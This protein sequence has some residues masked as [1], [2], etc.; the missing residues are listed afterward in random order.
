MTSSPASAGTP[1]LR[2]AWQR[3]RVQVLALLAVVGASLAY[4]VYVASECS[5][6]FDEASTI[7]DVDA[8]LPEL[9]RGPSR[10]HPPLM[11]WL[12]RLATALLGRSELGLRAV[13]LAFGCLLLLAVYLLALE[14]GLGATRA[15]VPVASLAVTPFFI[16]HATEA[17]QYA[18][19]A[20]FTTLATVFALRL[21]ARPLRLSWLVGLA[22]CSVAAAATHFFALPYAL[23]LWGSVAVGTL[24]AWK[25]RTL[26]ARDRK[27]LV[28]VVVA[29][30][31]LLGLLCADLFGL[32]RYYAHHALG[33]GGHHL[34]LASVW[35]AFSFLARPPWD[36]AYEALVSALG[37][38]VVAVR[39]RGL[40]RIIPLG[41]AFPP[42]AAVTLLSSGHMFTPR[43]LWP[44]FVFYHFGEVSAVL[45]LIEFV[46]W[47]VARAGAL[48]R[49][50]SVVAWLVLLV[51]FQARLSEFPTGFGAGGSIN[52]RALQR[53]FG[54]DRAEDTALVVYVG[55]AGTRI[56][57]SAY[58][59]PHLLTLEHFEPLPG[60]TRYLVAEFDSSDHRLHSEFAPLLKRQLGLSRSQ[61]RA[62]PQAKLAGNRFQRA[63][64][65]RLVVLDPA[66]SREGARA[67]GPQAPSPEPAEHANEDESGPA[68]D[69]GED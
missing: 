29:S 47:C 53:Y 26:P 61:W 4:R 62:L 34:A 58:P 51:P 3:H 65:A 19:M 66:E 30:V 57:G 40:A 32:V 13:S 12:V 56:M 7:H 21:L 10:E 67:T 68:P 24:R 64:R 69:D 42:V 46:T 31:L 49:R 39:S 2:A 50:L 36:P 6:W 35:R 44:S 22:V 52:Y 54:G 43:Y 48:A 18:M 37:L 63:A 14:L 23:V 17:R 20:A 38:V 28:G 27:L 60:I 45:A 1:G 55:Y 33:R 9:L 16:R 59:V 25:L 5:L 11:F 41:M 15:L 8:P